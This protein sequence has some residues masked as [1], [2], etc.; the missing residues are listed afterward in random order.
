[1]P[2]ILLAACNNHSSNQIAVSNNQ[3]LLKKGDSIA[4]LA[5]KILLQKVSNAIEL[6][7]TDY[8]I[9]FC[10][11]NALKLTDTLASINNVK[12]SRVTDRNRNS[13]NALKTTTDTVAW[14]KMKIKQASVIETNNNGEVYFYKPIVMAMPT[15]L[16]CHGKETEITKSTLQ[17]ISE[18]Y[19][20]DKALH[21]N[22]GELRG[23]WKIKM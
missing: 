18:K 7:G 11:E 13:N 1:M 19:P 3:Y 16:K 12:L 6:G 2:F 8:A 17:L 15:C 10:N 21:Y 23:M 9:S 4:T 22:A 14:N 20:K 5:Q